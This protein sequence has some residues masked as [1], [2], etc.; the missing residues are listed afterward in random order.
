MGIMSLVQN[1]TSRG[2]TYNDSNDIVMKLEC[3]SICEHFPGIVMK[4]GCCEYV[5]G[6]PA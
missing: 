4:L 3:G 5:R 1:T 2:N 6:S